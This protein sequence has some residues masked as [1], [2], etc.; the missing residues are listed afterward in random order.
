MEYS[1][2]IILFF[3]II[4]PPSLSAEA[5]TINKRKTPVVEVVEKVKDAVVNISTERLVKERINPFGDPFFD[6]FFSN[7]FDSFPQR[8]YKEQS[9][10]SGVIINKDGYILTNEHVILKAAKIKVT[11]SDE[12]I[13]D[14]ELVGADPKSDLAVVRIKSDTPF[15]FT[16]MGRSD[17]LMIGEPVI[18]IGNPFG[19]SHTI[20]TGVVSAINRSVKIGKNRIYKDFIQTDASI[21]P[22]NSG[23][24]LLNINGELIGINT[25]IYQQAEGIGFAIPILRAKR[26]VDDLIHYGSVHKAWIGMSVQDINA[27]LMNYFNLEKQKGV[28]I[29]KVIQN[30]PSAKAGLKRGDIITKVGTQDV[31]SREDYISI[32]GGY[33]ADDTISFSIIRDGEH[34]E[35]PLIAK[36]IPHEAGTEIA[37]EW[38]GIKIKPIDR[39]FLRRYG[40]IEKEG[41]MITSVNRSSA[42]YR[43]GLEAG[44]IIKQINNH[45]I[46][47]EKTF[48]EAIV[49]AAEKESILLLIRRGPYIYPL[50]IQPSL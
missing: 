42:A 2:L 37:Q 39:T 3:I 10:G 13:F 49:M 17:D 8:E 46:I 1:F 25:A 32:I 30:S 33:T 44:D 40:I 38:L 9:L 14:A 29:I 20:T 22:G 41:V 23:G 21:N 34:L 45:K 4:S 12:R 27:D 16:K 47:D 5:P 26:I 36:K 19:L 35:V 6:H 18:A 15:P 48:N 28:I 7:F 50:T 43:A 11:L 24:P 31:N